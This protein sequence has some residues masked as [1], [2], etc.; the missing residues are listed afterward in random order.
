M[1]WKDEEVD[2][3]CPITLE[4]ISS[5][6]YPP[7]IL[8][9]NKFDGVALASFIVS[10]CCF[11]NPLT[12][13]DLTFEDCRRLDSYLEEYCYHSTND[14]TTS[15]VVQDPRY[16]SH[17]TS[18]KISVAEAF[19]LN[20]SVQ[21]GR[22]GRNGNG[23]GQPVNTADADRMQVLRNTATVALA[24]LFVWD[25]HNTA[26]NNIIGT[27]RQAT[28][29]SSDSS[30][31]HE[32]NDL[33][34]WGFD[35]HRQVEDTS[36]MM[37][38][39]DT[40]DG[41][42][43]I[44]DDDDAINVGSRRDQY[45]R[46][47]RAFPPLNS[48]TDDSY[49]PSVPSDSQG[50]D[51]HLIECV[52]DISRQEEER[53]REHAIRL[54]TARRKILQ[55]A[56]LAREERR[57]QRKERLQ[58]GLVE[59]EKKKLEEEEIQRVKNEIASWKEDQWEKLRLVSEIKQQ[60][61]EEEEARQKREQEMNVKGNKKEETTTEEDKKRIE[62]ATKAQEEERK[63][64]KAKEKKK[65]AKE[66]KKKEKEEKRIAEE[67]LQRQQELEAKKSAAA[68]KCTAC[69]NGILDCG[70]EKYNQRYC[71][72]KCARTAKPPAARRQ[73]KHP[74]MTMATTSFLVF[75]LEM[76][77]VL[78][79]FQVSFEE[80]KPRPSPMLTATMWAMAFSIRPSQPRQLQRPKPQS[81]MTLSMMAKIKAPAIQI[82]DFIGL[83]TAPLIGGP[84]W[85]PVHCRV[86][87]T[88]GGGEGKTVE[89]QQKERE[90]DARNVAQVVYDYIPQNATSTKTLQKLIS[91]QP[92]QAQVRT[93][94]RK[95]TSL[96]SLSSTS[97]SEIPMTKNAAES[98]LSSTLLSSNMSPSLQSMY[99]QRA[100]IFC[101]EY[102][103]KELHLLYNNCWTFAFNLIKTMITSAEEVD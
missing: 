56:L 57:S 17:G 53:Q 29:S 92:V 31:P 23:R 73:R 75:V 26:T 70:F 35:L 59:F 50:Q 40:G 87:L 30:T 83:E 12:R 68:L 46:V 20:Q 55:N 45:D 2:V 11:Q 22:H 76:T 43:N 36:T 38:L 101:R 79:L 16:V 18:R 65:R 54:E 25:E 77:L 34:D 103:D 39:D 3:E 24:G 49:L 88:V 67:A 61:Q 62:A 51:E 100:E 41:W 58:Q 72:T 84:S 47:Q 19:S 1:W 93:F 6:P 71:S 15:G 10:R 66:K 21:V 28:A 8:Q 13:Q 80:Q 52:R 14:T 99:E 9:G 98:L 89:I 5:L 94:S 37:A 97:L 64:A 91:F 102:Q 42:F 60:Q 81:L 96:S 33:L 63:R 95:V 69:G 27:T 4:P 32:H 78:L 44:V 85:L 7:Y 74:P 48:D 86:V 82:N 90:Q